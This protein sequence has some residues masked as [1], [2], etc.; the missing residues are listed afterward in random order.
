MPER[1]LIEESPDF[2]P[3]LGGPLFQLF[4]RTHLSG[5]ALELM[6]RRIL[7]S[8]LVAWMPLLVL[9]LLGGHALGGGVKIPFLVDIETHVRFLI[10][11]PVLIAAELIVHRQILPVVQQFTVRHM[12]I[13]EQVPKFSAAIN[14]A[15]RVRNSTVLELVL[16]V[17]VYT[18]GH[19][20]WRNG[21]ALEQGSWYATPDGTNLNLTYAGYWLAYVSVPLFQFIL[22][23][24]YFRI[25]TW[26]WLLWRISKLDLRLT[27]TH[28]DRTGGLGFL[29]DTAYAYAPILFA[30]GALLAGVIASRIF[31]DGQ[32]LMAFKAEVAL[33]VVVF[34][35]FFLGP[36]A[37]FSGKLAQV[38]RKGM[39]EYGVLASR[40]VQK[41]DEKWVQ[42][43]ASRT[44][45]LLGSGDI[46]SLADL[47]NSI[48]VIREMRPIPVGMNAVI[49]LVAATVSPLLPLTLTVFSA[50]EVLLKV[51]QILL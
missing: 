14:A 33:F 40:Y 26:F 2:S 47:G 5:D 22:L 34:I 23:R 31:Y 48:A 50:E 28:P 19:W 17:L 21:V 44:E 9:A 30:Q 10:A 7:I 8:V 18:T 11:L 12:I 37:V 24:W 36:L 39:R 4:R 38:K 15:T 20:F 32:V 16:L 42:G 6:S 25:V 45:E 1:E 49:I 35:L 27:P 46:Q 29:G 3:V 13:A 41:F 43:N 51:I